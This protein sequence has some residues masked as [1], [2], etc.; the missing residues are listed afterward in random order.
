MATI[1]KAASEHVHGVVEVHLA[2]FQ[3]F[4][5]EILGPRFL[6][7]LYRAFVLAPSGI[8]LVAIEDAKVVGFVAGTSK[9][10]SFFRGLLLKRWHKFLYAGVPA[11]GSHPM[12]VGK[13]FLKAVLYRGEQPREIPNSALLSS[14]AVAPGGAGKGVGRL[15]LDA[16]CR[17]AEQHGC[18]SVVLTTNRDD[19]EQVNRFY[20]ANGLEVHSALLKE[21]GRWMNLYMRNLQH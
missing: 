2:A 21:K 11:I 13:K 8:F 17:T 20:L 7:E 6:T 16:F 15:L 4:F 12:R 10:E 19:N 1:A 5:L 3:G 14:I 9:P 18:S